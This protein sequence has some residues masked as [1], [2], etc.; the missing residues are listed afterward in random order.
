[1]IAI[2]LLGPLLIDTTYLLYSTI[3]S[4]T[5]FKAVDEIA[6]YLAEMY[7]KLLLFSQMAYKLYAP[8]TYNSA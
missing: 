3:V 7:I 8:G 5:T 4:P 6:V 1:M 2:F